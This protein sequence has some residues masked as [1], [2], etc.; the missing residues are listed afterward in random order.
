M[1]RTFPITIALTLTLALAA[2]AAS[3]ADDPVTDDGDTPPPAAGPTADAVLIVEPSATA[4]G[5]GISV[6]DALEQIGGDQPLLVNG[7]LFVDADGGMLL[8]EAIA[9]SFPP[10]CGGLR[11][12]VRGLD[13]N[14]QVLEEA[15]GVRWAET[16]QLLGRLVESD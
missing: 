15:E 4:S 10:Q 2:C 16:V 7:S 5:P 14:A 3:G 13:P 6:A 11:L 8:C 9:E 12:E 1:R